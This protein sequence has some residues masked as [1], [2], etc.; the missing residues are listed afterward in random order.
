MASGRQVG[1]V[2]SRWR[3][4][5]RR[6]ISLVPSPISQSL[7]SRTIRSAAVFARVT[8]ATQDLNGIVPCTHR[9]FTAVE[10]SQR[11][12]APR[13][14][15]P[16]PCATRPHRPASAPHES[17]WPCSPTCA[18]PLH[19]DQALVEL[20]AL[21]RVVERNI[22]RALG[23]SQGHGADGNPARF[24]RAHE[25]FEAGSV[26]AELIVEGNA[27]VLEHDFAGVRSA[28]SEFVLQHAVLEAGGIALDDERGDLVRVADL[29]ARARR[30]DDGAGVAA[31]RAVDL[32]ARSPPM[33]RR[34]EWP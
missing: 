8:H 30:K 11:S 20:F 15:C 3:A 26:F 14:A 6:W 7:A 10:L 16:G 9:D 13:R 34:H 1:P 23:Q 17:P 24:E 18:R 2:R 4:R 32:G 12:R 19:V 25:L 28:E 33:R 31:V 29:T 27:T 22:E 21:F 5:M